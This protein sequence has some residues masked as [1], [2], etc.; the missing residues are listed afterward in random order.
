LLEKIIEDLTRELTN[1]DNL[2]QVLNY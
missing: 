1:R 2:I